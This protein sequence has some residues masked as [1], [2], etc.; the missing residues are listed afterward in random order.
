MNSRQAT[1]ELALQIANKSNLLT[2]I[3]DESI[4]LLEDF[5]HLMEVDH[6]VVLKNGLT[7]RVKPKEFIKGMM[8]IGMHTGEE[9][10]SEDREFRYQFVEALNG[11]TSRFSCWD[12][13]Y[14]AISGECIGCGF[15]QK[16]VAEYLES[17]G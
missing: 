5:N 17:Q 16:V 12:K 2:L 9:V 11:I 15:N 8:A 7:Y 10:I 13:V 1:Y 6:L 4:P 14:N 3:L